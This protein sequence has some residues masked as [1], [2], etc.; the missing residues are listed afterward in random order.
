MVVCF[1]GELARL[2]DELARS[3]HSPP[4]RACSL[5]SLATHYLFIMRAISCCSFTKLSIENTDLYVTV[6]CLSCLY[7]IVFSLPTWQTNKT[8]VN[9]FIFKIKP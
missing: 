8:S 4:G 6:Q 2:Q 1:Q 3:A 5:R 7:V 9:F